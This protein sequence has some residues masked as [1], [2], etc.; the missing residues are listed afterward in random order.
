MAL[1]SQSNTTQ[2]CSNEVHCIGKGNRTI[3]PPVGLCRIFRTGVH[4]EMKRNAGIALIAVMAALMVLSTIAL[5]LAAS[6]QTEA[7]VE[8][9][10]WDQLQGEQLARS[11][12]EFASYLE[13]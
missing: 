1:S 13:M 11:G 7:R 9:A 12:Q 6:V 10:D 5:G 4:V 8:A 3:A 2:G